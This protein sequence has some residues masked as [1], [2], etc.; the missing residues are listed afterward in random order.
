MLNVAIRALDDPFEGI[1]AALER[2]VGM[3]DIDK[4][5]L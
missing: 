4:S 1:D 3:P 2:R 5:K